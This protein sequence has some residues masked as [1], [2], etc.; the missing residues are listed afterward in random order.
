MFTPKLFTDSLFDDFFHDFD[1][2]DHKLYG[3]HARVE[4]LTDIKELDDHYAIEVDLPGFHKDEIDITLDN[5]YLT[6]KAHKGLKEDEKD[7]KGV[8]IRQEKTYGTL[9]RSFY[10]GENITS[11]DLKAK[12]EN[13]VL[14]ISIPK[15]E[16]T[17]KLENKTITIE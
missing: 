4:M 15:K 7:K 8:I 16:E 5:G 14:I 1:N 6:I 2:I 12:Y 3:K 9:A 11:D 10:I 17:R 13:G